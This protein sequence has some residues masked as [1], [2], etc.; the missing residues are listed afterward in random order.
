MNK[1]KYQAA[2][3]MVKSLSDFVDEEEKQNKEKH[4]TKYVMVRVTK[5]VGTGEIRVEFA[6]D[7]ARKNYRIAGDEL[8]NS[9]VEVIYE[10]EVD[11]DTLTYGIKY[12]AH[13][14]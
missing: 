1:D 3:E 13:R 4:S 8:L 7:E 2:R 14:E 10:E 12:T 5:D 9:Q 11:V 6:N